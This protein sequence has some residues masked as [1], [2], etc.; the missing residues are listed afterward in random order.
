MFEKIN[1][2]NTHDAPPTIFTGATFNPPTTYWLDTLQWIESNTP[3]TAII[4][5]WWDYGYWITA[6]SDRITLVDNATLS[7]KQTRLK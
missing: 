2:I 1:W 3:E 6:L 4:A 7:T 5:S